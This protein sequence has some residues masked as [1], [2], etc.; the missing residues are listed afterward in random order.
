M[1]VFLRMY[2]DKSTL[3][4]ISKLYFSFTRVKLFHYKTTDAY[5]FAKVYKEY[6]LFYKNY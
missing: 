6:W 2:F 4:D 5:E 1:V 3:G